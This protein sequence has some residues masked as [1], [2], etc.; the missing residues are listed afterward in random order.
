[1][2]PR[3]AVARADAGREHA[4]RDLVHRAIAADGDDERSPLFRRGARERDAV[5]TAL[6][7][8]DVDRRAR[9]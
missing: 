6:G 5:P 3:I 1:M 4:A 7:E 9:A 8:D 2:N